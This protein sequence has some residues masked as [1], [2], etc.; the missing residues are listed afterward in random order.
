[1]GYLLWRDS[2][3]SRP[4]PSSKVGVF[5]AAIVILV[6][7]LAVAFI[8]LS[9]QAAPIATVVPATTNTPRVV[10]ASPESITKT[11]SGSLNTEAFLLQGGNYQIDWSAR[12]ANFGNV[13]CFHGGTLRSVD[14]SLLIFE[15]AG[16]ATVDAG[17]AAQGSTNVYNLPR[18]QY[19]FQMNS[20]CTWSVTIATQ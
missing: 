2:P 6:L 18:S 4:K 20:G 14:A 3:L 9:P 11:G 16:T 10:Q 13:G 8:A 19:Y 17:Q 1:M 15:E 12:D 5:P 7:L